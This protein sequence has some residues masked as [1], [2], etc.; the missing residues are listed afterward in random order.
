MIFNPHTEADRAAMLSAIGVESVDDLFQVVPA[1]YRYPKLNL[2]AP[3]SEMEILRE[4]QEINSTNETLGKNACFLGAGA[5]N[6]FVPSIVDQLVSR[7]EF[8]TAY[9]PYQAELSQGTLQSIYEYQ[10]MVVALTGMEAANA[11][12]Y[13]GA[14]SCAEAVVT[15][16]NVVKGKQRNKVLISSRL[17]PEYCEVIHTYMQGTGVEFVVASD[18]ELAGMLD[19]SVICV[20]VQNPNFLG[21]MTA[22]VKLQ[23]LADAVHAVKALFIV[24]VDPISLGLFTPPGEY[25]ADIVVGEGQS[26]GSKVNYGGPYLGLFA[27]R[28]KLV[29]KMA[30]RLVGQTEDTEGNRGFVLTLSAREQH[31]R[32]ERATSNICSNE[33]L[34]A[35]AAGIY[36]EV[37]G[38]SGLHKVAELCYHKAHY[39]A[40]Q[41]T[42]L[43]GFELVGDKPFFKEFAVRCPR[44]VAEVNEHLLKQ[45]IIGGFD[46]GRVYEDMRDCMLVCV[47]EMNTKAEID[48]LVAAL[49]DVKR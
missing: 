16:L 1:A 44:P 29:R 13:D 34:V 20:I 8:Y 2:P 49:G 48:K 47:T 6:H 5:Y 17:H 42:A 10:S 11:S 4:L 3:L 35:L 45:S 14:T 38:K 22:P 15:A 7:G 31:I 21:E 24:A 46:L 43:D 32:R 23:E 33:A 30:G 12:H 39:A 40:Q 36:L 27:C 25:G 41:I 37:M 26:L 9:T 18:E 19:K 28:K